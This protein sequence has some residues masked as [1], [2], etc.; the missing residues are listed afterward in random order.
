MFELALDSV[1]PRFAGSLKYQF[2]I[3]HLSIAYLK[4]Y[5][6]VT[7]HRERGLKT[8]DFGDKDLAL[9]PPRLRLVEFVQLLH[10]IV[11]HALQ[12][13]ATLRFLIVGDE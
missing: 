7:R 11:A 1:Q 9:L 12:A 6:V 3:K 4:A 13:Y 8:G 2:G 5:L 10:E